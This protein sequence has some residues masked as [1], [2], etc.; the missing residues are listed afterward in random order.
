[1]S[2]NEK[3]MRLQCRMAFFVARSAAAI[4]LGYVAVVC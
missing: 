4:D 3:A 1:M 2:C